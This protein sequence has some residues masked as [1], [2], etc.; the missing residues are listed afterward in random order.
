MPSL[1]R[2]FFLG[3]VKGLAEKLKTNLE[4]G[5]PG[6]ETDFINRKKAFGSNTYPR[7]KGKSFWV[8]LYI[9]FF[10]FVF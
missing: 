4:N 1:Y 8:G 2:Y 5:V 6:E 9:Y 3:Q 10:V 7:K